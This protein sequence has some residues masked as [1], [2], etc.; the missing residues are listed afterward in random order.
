MGWDRGSG[1]GLGVGVG[2]GVCVGV[3]SGVGVATGV[4]VGVGVGVARG[5]D[6]AVGAAVATGVGAEAA[7]GVGGETANGVAWGLE[8]GLVAVV[9]GAVWV[10]VAEGSLHAARL[11][12]NSRRR[13]V[14]DKH[15][16][17]FTRP[18]SYQY[19]RGRSACLAEG[20][21][22]QWRAL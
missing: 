14:D 10:A 20:I 1:V 11:K 6:V 17:V 8:T 22:R 19:T 21:M 3:G 15:A 18:R 13:A 4:F 12:A 2:D 16:G 9:G 7:V 5:T